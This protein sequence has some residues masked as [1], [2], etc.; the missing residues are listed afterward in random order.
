MRVSLSYYK[1][2]PAEKIYADFERQATRACKEGAVRLISLRSAEAKCVADVLDKAVTKLNRADVAV[3]HQG[4][5]AQ[6]ASR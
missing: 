5:M 1:S 3:L 2:A 6:I 4:G